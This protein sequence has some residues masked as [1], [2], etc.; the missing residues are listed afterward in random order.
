MDCDG[1]HAFSIEPLYCGLAE[2][3]LEVFRVYDYLGLGTVKS[4]MQE[5]MQ[6]MVFPSERVLDIQNMS[7]RGR[8]SRTLSAGPKQPPSLRIEG[9]GS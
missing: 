2:L 9:R 4:K 7:G 6:S 3:W 8:A 1:K 5:I